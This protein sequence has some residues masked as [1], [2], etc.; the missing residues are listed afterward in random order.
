MKSLKKKKKKTK[1]GRS[2]I[3]VEKR[4]VLGRVLLRRIAFELRSQ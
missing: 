4:R 3:V 1:Q 2:G